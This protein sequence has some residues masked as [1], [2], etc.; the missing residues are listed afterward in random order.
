MSIQ[1][2]AAPVSW[3]QVWAR[4]LE[5]HHLACPSESQPADVA[6]AICGAHA[7]VLSAAE[8][9]IAIRTR[10]LTRSDIRHALWEEHSLV[11]TR[12]PR[13]T[14][15]LL[16]TMELALWTGA[17]AMLPPGRSPFPE[18]VQLSLSQTD[19]VVEAIASAVEDVELTLEELTA[20]IVRRAGPWA[21]ELTMEAF[22]GMWPRWR[23]A[24]A[25]AFH[26]SVLCFGPNR[27]SRVTYTSPRRWLPDFRLAHGPTALTWLVRSYLHAFG[28]STPAQ[29]AQW[30]AVPT[31]WTADVLASL[32]D[33]L[34]EI[35]VEGTPAWVAAGDTLFSSPPPRGVRLLP[36]FDAYSYGCQ[37]R[38]L[39]HPGR[40]A[41]RMPRGSFQVLLIDGLVAGLWHQRRSGERIEVIV[42]PLDSLSASQRDE[43]EHQVARIGE[44]L[45]GEARLSIGTVTTGPHA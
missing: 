13:G 42:E 43:L 9:S 16:P 7:Q 31:G 40:A 14:V 36:Y 33:E 6:R 29:L 39:L 25:A 8:L 20:A 37:P 21:G 38:A 11:K 41:E 45:E 28:P 24:E 17:L 19:A 26:R 22:Q 30:L 1:T 34:E 15:F 2:T 18:G 5:R 35:D 4:R 12:G 10:K 23:Q 32:S 3:S 27:G 44:I